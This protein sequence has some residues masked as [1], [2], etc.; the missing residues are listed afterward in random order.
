MCCSDTKSM[1]HASVQCRAG[2]AKLPDFPSRS[3]YAEYKPERW[4]WSASSEV[5]ELALG[6]HTSLV[7]RGKPGGELDAFYREVLSITFRRTAVSRTTG[8]Q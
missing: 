8:M 4:I 1:I 5:T 6:L 2:N 3:L 7:D